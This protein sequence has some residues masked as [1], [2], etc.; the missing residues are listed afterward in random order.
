MLL[1]LRP[2]AEQLQGALQYAVLAGVSQVSSAVFSVGSVV[3]AQ[4]LGLFLAVADRFKLGI[5]DAKGLEYLDNRI[6]ALLT[7]CEVVFSATAFVGIAFDLDGDRRIGREELAV[8]FQHRQA[9]WLDFRLVKIKINAALLCEGVVGVQVGSHLH[10]RHGGRLSGSHG[11]R[12]RCGRLSSNRCGLRC[13]RG[14]DGGAA[15]GAQNHGRSQA[16]DQSQA[17]K[18]VHQILQRI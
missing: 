14:G 7:K 6:R 4:G 17:A 3:V 18:S 11:S 5:L 2:A 12:R 15:A 1:R 13:G 16:C 9:L 10:C 8:Q